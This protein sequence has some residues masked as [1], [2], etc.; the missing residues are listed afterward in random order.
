MTPGEA[1]DERFVASNPIPRLCAARKK[2]EAV[3][4]R[5]RRRRPADEANRVA[6]GRNVEAEEGSRRRVCFPKLTRAVEGRKR[7]DDD[8]KAKSATMAPCEEEEIHR[9]GRPCRRLFGG[10]DRRFRRL[11]DDGAGRRR[12]WRTRIAAAAARRGRAALERRPRGC[13]EAEEEKH[14]ERE[15]TDS[16]GARRATR[17]L[18]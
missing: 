8:A 5:R 13:G 6:A 16:G 10:N 18:A 4:R 12:P 2:R 14:R 7:D 11:R 9:R 3:S 15:E 17:E 1:K